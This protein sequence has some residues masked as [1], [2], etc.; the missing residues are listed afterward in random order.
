MSFKCGIFLLVLVCG[1][2]SGYCKC[3]DN[4]PL[5]CRELKHFCK[6]VFT[7]VR[8]AVAK[9]CPITCGIPCEPCRDYVLDCAALRDRGDCFHS[10]ITTMTNCPKT[11]GVCS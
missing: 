1:I 8:W 9:N 10:P 4:S 2:G 7:D 6:S 3:H 5:K 11:C